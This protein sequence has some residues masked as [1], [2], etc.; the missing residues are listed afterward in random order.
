M[1]MTSAT[2]AAS[3][4]SWRDVQC[5]SVSSPSQFF[6]KT[7]TTSWPSRL[8]SHAATDESTPPERPTT[9]RCLA[10]IR[11]VWPRVR[12]PNKKGGTS[13]LL[14]FLCRSSGLQVPPSERQ[15][16]LPLGLLQVSGL[17]GR[18]LLRFRA[19]LRRCGCRGAFLRVEV[20]GARSHRH[21]LDGRQFGAS[22]RVRALPRRCLFFRRHRRPFGLRRVPLGLQPGLLARGENERLS[23]VIT[24]LG[25]RRKGA[26]RKCSDD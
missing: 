7:P 3:I 12:G 2:D 24:D 6:M 5:M 19:C 17:V 22:L 1:P 13:R 11:S 20:F 25:Q 15:G 10:F 21:V 8:S 26:K 16:L 9:M 18:R 14:P 4:R 23:F